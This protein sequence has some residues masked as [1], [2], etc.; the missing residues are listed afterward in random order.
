MVS[1]WVGKNLSEVGFKQFSVDTLLNGAPLKF[2][3][4]YSK[5]LSKEELVK[6]QEEEKKAF[7]NSD[8]NTANED[9]GRYFGY[10]DGINNYL[11]LPYNLTIQKNQ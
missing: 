7:L 1:P 8:G 4:D 3:L 11:K 9:Y 2:N 6:R 10:E 5:I